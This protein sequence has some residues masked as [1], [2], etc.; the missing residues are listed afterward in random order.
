MHSCYRSHRSYGIDAGVPSDARAREARQQRPRSPHLET[1][2]ES[3]PCRVSAS[4][5]RA[6][7]TERLRETERHT[8]VSDMGT[9]SGERGGDDDTGRH[10]E[11][12]RGDDE[13]DGRGAVRHE[14]SHACQVVGKTQSL[15]QMETSS[16]L[17]YC[18]QNVATTQVMAASADVDWQ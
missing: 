15:V 11:R 8:R 5:P 7:I 10:V 14:K 17:L 13:D 12:H 4:S 2:A 1:N 16:H 3:A 6:D 18:H 9:C